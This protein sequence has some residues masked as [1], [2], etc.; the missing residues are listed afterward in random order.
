MIMAK[1]EVE[2]TLKGRAGTAVILGS[3]FSNLL[4]G[5]PTKAV[6]EYSDLDQMPVPTVGGHP[7]KAALYKRNGKS[8]FLLFAGRTHFYEG[9]PIEDIVASVEAAA[10]LGC[11]RLLL[12]N[13]AGSLRRGLSPG[14]WLLPREVAYFPEAPVFAASDTRSGPDASLL[15]ISPRFRSGIHSS[16]LKAG[17]PLSDGVLLWNTGPCYETAAEGRAARYIGADAVSMSILHELAA[18]NLVG[19]EAAVLSWITNYT[20]NVSHAPSSHKDVIAKGLKGS[21]LLRPI[22][23]A[24]P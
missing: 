7:G 16:A 9:V 4:K 18:A 12:V 5:I 22:L 8:P 17:V 23:D 20:P 19:L 3:G 11:R 1:V 6:F 21:R 10:G 15:R 14:S 2:K 13:A 24:L